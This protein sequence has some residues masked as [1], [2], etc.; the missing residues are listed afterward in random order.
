MKRLLKR[1]MHRESAVTTAGQA[2]GTIKRG[3]QPVLTPEKWR[4]GVEMLQQGRTDK[5]AYQE[6]GIGRATFY[7]YESA[8]RAGP[9]EM[10][11]EQIYALV[12]RRRADDIRRLGRPETESRDATIVR[13]LAA[14]EAP[15]AL[16]IEYGIKASVVRARVKT[17]H[18]RQHAN[19][20]GPQPTPNQA[21]REPD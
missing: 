14:G 15:T 3:R 5:A 2:A 7:L 9:A 10:T 17:H 18:Q 12:A 13:R 8:M 16:G 20:Q 6:L 11:Q 19:R 1:S 4:R 21:P